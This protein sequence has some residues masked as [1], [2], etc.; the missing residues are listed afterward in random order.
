MKF[1]QRRAALLLVLLCT[2]TIA[3]GPAVI[4]AQDT[5]TPDND[6]TDNVTVTGSGIVGRVFEAL[7][8]ASGTEAAFDVQTTG[9]NAGL[10]AFCVGAADIA[11][12]N[13][14]LSADEE[15]ACIANEVVFLE[16]LIADDILAFITHPD[17]ANAECITEGDLTTLL[18][19]SAS[20]STLDWGNINGD[21]ELPLSVYLPPANTPVFAY[22]DRIVS[23]DGARND[24]A[25]VADDAAVIS[26][27][28]ATPGA[29]GVVAL[30]SLTGESADGVKI[31]QINNFERGSCYS[32]SPASTENGSYLTGER[33]FAYVNAGG[34][35]KPGLSDVLNFIG[36]EEAPAAVMAAGFS[37]PSDEA[38]VQLRDTL[39]NNTM[40]RVF[41]QEV[42]TFIV[43]DSLTGEIAIRG[44]SF[45]KAY[46]DELTTVLQGS[47]A[48]LT[49]TTELKGEPEGIRGLCNGEYNLIV[50]QRGLNEEQQANCTA[51]N[52]TPLSFGLG[53][54]VAVL[55]SST[56]TDYLTC[57]TTEQIAAV[58][59]AEAEDVLP[60][61]WN[62]VSA[63][64]PEEQVLL[65]AP[66]ESDSANGLLTALTVGQ[67]VPIRT[68]AEVSSDPLYRA[69]A[70][71]N[72]KGALTYMSWTDYQ[73]VIDN[74]QANI[75]LVGV[76]GG[77]GC[78]TPSLETIADG[79][80]PLARP[81]TL[82]VNKSALTDVA[83]QS[84]LWLVFSDANYEILTSAG[85][86]GLSLDSLAAIREQ[87]QTA[88]DEAAA[89]AL[90]SI[91]PEST[92]EAPIETTPTVEATSDATVEAPTEEASEEAPTEE[93][94]EEPTVEATVEPTVEPTLEPTPEPTTE[95]T[96]APTVEPTTEPTAAPTSTP[97]PEA[98][99]T[100]G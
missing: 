63:D 96:V 55:L 31:L 98:T 81:A 86:V 5:E 36:G 53:S 76:D 27:V 60:T 12:A 38:L 83:V 43:P 52:V 22:L 11:L 33:L 75:Q 13:R 100:A 71:A 50:T 32:P 95:P 17:N 82:I 14:P 39:A 56:T 40:G 68:N 61:T 25:V 37:A 80:Y 41:S 35:A 24:A 18:A 72:V 85:F 92:E 93:P 54:E 84:W 64:L 23:G 69:A 57:L 34:M 44:G 46:I 30:S 3:V 77:S 8:A 19:P 73:S 58:V 29:F 47:Y 2:L 74:Q 9:T 48:G 89:E 87:L 20:G 4:S 65:F 1:I 59:R 26:S 16:L 45:A 66:F 79:S 21:A 91:N 88:F 94:T 67:A 28:T 42:L 78:I 70:T 6:T 49:V 99:A 7:R 51:N 97:E 90:V 15:A 62:Q 10:Q